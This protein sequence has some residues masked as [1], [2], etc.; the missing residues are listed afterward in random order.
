MIT[1]T[2]TSCGDA[3]FLPGVKLLKVGFLARGTARKLRLHARDS[4]FPDI[5]WRIRTIT[6][7]PE[8]K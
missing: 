1:S 4:W 6:G 2:V 5:A 7:A 3:V 8:E